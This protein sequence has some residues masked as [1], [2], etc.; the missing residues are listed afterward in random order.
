[1]N[2]T[3]RLLGEFLRM[4]RIVLWYS[5]EDI[6]KKVRL[7]RTSVVNIEAGRQRI[8]LDQVEDFAKA[9]RCKPIH[10]AKAIW[11]IRA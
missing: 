1:M 2:N 5:Q 11:G 6:A 9:L 10:I 7:N 3:Y 8:R 4:R